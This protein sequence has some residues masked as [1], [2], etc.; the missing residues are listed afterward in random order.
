VNAVINNSTGYVIVSVAWYKYRLL[1]AD[2]T[3]HYD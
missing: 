2:M 3:V 1:K